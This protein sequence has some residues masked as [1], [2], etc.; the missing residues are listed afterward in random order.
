MQ[1]ESNQCKSDNIK[2]EG[3]ST[4]WHRRIAIA[5]F[6]LEEG[7]PYLSEW[8]G[9]DGTIAFVRTKMDLPKTSA[10]R[11]TLKIV[12]QEVSACLA[13]NIDY[14]G[15][16]RAQKNLKGCWPVIS[17]K[18]TFVVNLVAKS[19]EDSFGLR[20]TTRLV[21]EHKTEANEEPVTLLSAVYGL[22]LRLK[23]TTVKIAKRQ[24]GSF[25]RDSEWAK[26]SL[27]WAL[28]LLIRFKQIDITDLLTE[29]DAFQSAVKKLIPDSAALPDHSIQKSLPN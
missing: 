3:F 14:D 11:D 24:H 1:Q 9:N 6:F 12:F 18:D 27:G 19:V 22:V 29:S 13:E 17:L 4:P 5:H 26:A 20:N 25:D 10:T 21:N 16:S 23:P 15:I 2:E 7:A 8:H 28:Q